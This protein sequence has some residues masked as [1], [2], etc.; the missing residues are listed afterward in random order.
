MILVLK[1]SP[2]QEAEIDRLLSAQQDP[3]SP[4]FHSWLTPSEFGERFGLAIEDIDAIT[5]CSS[6][7]DYESKE[8]RK[9]TGP[10]N[11]VGK[12]VESK[13]PLSASRLR[14]P[15]R[16]SHRHLFGGDLHSCW[17]SAGG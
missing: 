14:A 10:W 3:S 5:A 16:V 17:F 8:S 4:L 11:L 2:E 13:R 6:R 1:P 7:E 12:P 9:A 15:G